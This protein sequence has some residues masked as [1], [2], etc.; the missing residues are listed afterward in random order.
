MGIFMKQIALSKTGKRYANKYF[1]LVDDEDYDFLMQWNWAVAKVHEKFYVSRKINDKHIYI[2]RVIMKAEKHQEID[3]I[4]NNPLNNQKSN[5][6]FCTR[7]QNIA[8]R[9]SRGK[10]KYLG[11][12]K[13]IKRYIKQDGKIVEYIYWEV[14][15][16]ARKQRLFRGMY[17]TEIAAAI[18]YNK[19][20][21]KYHGEFAKLNN[22]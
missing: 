1:A 16:R 15:L 19:A 10:S 4:D 17:R 5:L 11:V 8:N 12:S 18:A 21:L 22:I 13:R 9:K 14:G 2:H 3:H 6:R 20:A 7:S